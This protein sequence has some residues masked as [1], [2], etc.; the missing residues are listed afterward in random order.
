MKP[1]GAEKRVKAADTHIAGKEREKDVM[2][3]PKD[4]HPR[5]IGDKGEKHQR[6][7]IANTVGGVE[8]R[9]R[10]HKGEDRERNT[11]DG[12][13]CNTGKASLR[14]EEEGGMI[15]EH[16]RHGNNLQGTAV[17]GTIRNI[18]QPHRRQR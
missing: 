17:H 18:L 1:G 3:L 16:A 13:K 6:Q 5:D 7:R 9:L 8:I 14:Q 2:P 4:Q 11:P 10:H 15:D 12:T